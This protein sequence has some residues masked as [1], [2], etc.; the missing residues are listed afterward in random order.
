[1][2]C[3]EQQAELMPKCMVPCYIHEG[4]FC[5]HLF[6]GISEISIYFLCHA[7]SVMS[8]A[9]GLLFG[10]FA[11]YGAMQTSANPKNVM[12]SLGK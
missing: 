5:V 2:K 8:L 9:M 3:V 11:G 10:G 4:N 7:G 1:M 12:V 6:S